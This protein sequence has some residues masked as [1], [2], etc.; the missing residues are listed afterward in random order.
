MARRMRTLALASSAML[1]LAASP[2]PA[3]AESVAVPVQ[4]LQEICRPLNA[5]AIV[6]GVPATP[7]IQYC[8]YLSVFPD[9]FKG[10]AYLRLAGGNVAQIRVWPSRELEEAVQST[11][12]QWR[13]ELSP[14]LPAGRSVCSEELA[15]T[16]VKSKLSCAA[17]FII[18]GQYADATRVL[19]LV[20]PADR[21]AGYYRAKIAVAVLG[22]TQD[23]ANWPAQRAAARALMRAGSGVGSYYLAIDDNLSY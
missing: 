1:L 2:L 7:S 14:T 18:Y 9:G 5:S 4:P 13:E 17:V 22:A 3:R 11:V 20:A 23:N 6:N 12:G 8:G 16:Q 19:S 15:S 21:G 10:V